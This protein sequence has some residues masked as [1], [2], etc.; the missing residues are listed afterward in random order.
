MPLRQTLVHAGWEVEL[1]GRADVVREPA[2]GPVRIEELK[3]VWADSPPAAAAR[4]RAR[5]QVRLYAR[6]WSAATGRD[7]DAELVWLP[8]GEG[9]PERERLAPAG[10]AFEEALRRALDGW[11]ARG[12]DARAR[13]AAAAG[14][15]AGVA[16]PYPAWRPGQEPWP[17]PWPEPS[18]AAS[19]SSW[20]RPPGA[21]RPRPCSCPPCATRWRPGAGSS[22]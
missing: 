4:R 9:S 11:V 16:L 13:R 14:A 21:G 6:M 19:S 2:S 3:T 5:R 15:A 12:E 7:V 1:T 17:V 18:T 8:I 10:P 22:W 20:R